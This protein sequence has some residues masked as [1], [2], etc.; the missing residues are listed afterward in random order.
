MPQYPCGSALTAEY[1][2]RNKSRQEGSAAGYPPKMTPKPPESQQGQRGCLVIDREKSS[3]YGSRRTD[4]VA[5]ERRGD[6]RA[7][8]IRPSTPFDI[9]RSHGG[10][11]KYSG[12]CHKTNLDNN[13]TIPNA[14]RN[15]QQWVRSPSIGSDDSAEHSTRSRIQPS[16]PALDFK[17]SKLSPR[18]YMHRKGGVSG[19][20]KISSTAKSPVNDQTD[21]M[22]QTDCASA[23]TKAV[24]QRY[25]KDLWN[26]GGRKFDYDMD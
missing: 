5:A 21:L 24:R 25:G 16:P 3:T 23:L 22:A 12:Y 20:A 7:H 17:K 14:Q 6:S 19:L 18:K 15:D 11:D 26:K 13:L 4:R 2:Y 8:I 10:K 1:N 9:N